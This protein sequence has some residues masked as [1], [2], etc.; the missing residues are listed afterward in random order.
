MFLVDAESGILKAM[1]TFTIKFS[2]D[3]RDILEEQSAF[4][5]GKVGEIIKRVNTQFTTDYM[6]KNATKKLIFKRR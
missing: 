1:R 3:I 2:E 5:N 6:I 4:E